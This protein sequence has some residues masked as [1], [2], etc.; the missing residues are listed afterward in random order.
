MEIVQKINKK[1]SK[2]K[3]GSRE[4]IVKELKLGKNNQLL[5]FIN[6]LQQEFLTEINEIINTKS[7]KT[8][9]DIIQKLS[10]PRITQLINIILGTKDIPEPVD[11]KF[12][13]E[14]L[15]LPDILELGEL[16]VEQNK[17]KIV[18]GAGKD[19]FQAGNQM[20]MVTPP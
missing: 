15:S 20:Q 10:I 19:F 14:E 7:T 9:V 6:T 18:L 5:Y 16:V 11:E 3:L 12:V 13:E 2:I 8:I 1:E 4:F 17:F